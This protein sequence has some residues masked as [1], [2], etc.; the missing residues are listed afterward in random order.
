MRRDERGRVERRAVLG[1]VERQRERHERGRAGEQPL[2]RAPA[3]RAEPRLLGCE[4]RGALAHGRVAAEL[5]RAQVQRR[6]PSGG[7]RRAQLEHDLEGAPHRRGHAL[8]RPSRATRTVGLSA[9]RTSTRTMSAASAMSA[10]ASVAPRA[11]LVD[12]AR[13]FA[14]RAP[15]DM[16]QRAPTCLA[17]GDHAPFAA[18]SAAEKTRRVLS[19]SASSRRWWRSGS[20]RASGGERSF[21]PMFV[22]EPSPLRTPALSFPPRLPY[23]V[24]CE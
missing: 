9:T 22:A 20:G 7:G 23:I 21:R 18:R 10:R 24:S 17:G 14:W 13:L 12:G 1:G 4:L 3:A 19:A 16:R 11:L 5:G 6:E 2:Q 15:A 8:E